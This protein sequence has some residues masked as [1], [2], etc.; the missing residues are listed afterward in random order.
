MEEIVLQT[1]RKAA[2]DH[3]RAYFEFLFKN[4]QTGDPFPVDFDTAWPLAYSSK[5]N[6]KRALVENTAFYEGEDYHILKAEDMVKRPQGGGPQT[7]KII[8]SIG[9]FEY[10][11]ARKVR[12]VFDVYRECRIVV[13]K[14]AVAKAAL[15]YHLRRYLANHEQVPFGHFS[16]LQELTTK[17]IGPLEMKGYTVPENMLPDISVGKAFCRWLREEKGL[18]PDSFPTYEHVFE[19]GRTVFPKAY[20]NHLLSDF[21]E[22]FNGEWMK[23]RAE[24][25]FGDRDE[26]SLVYLQKI[27]EGPKAS[28]QIPGPPSVP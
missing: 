20:P 24:K 25:Y 2:M 8:L 1:G 17:L 18:D 19:D 9:C 15:P 21:V 5:A 23:N 11:I 27:I 26:A 6:A 22:H 10:F 4:E 28:T 12:Q 16:I 7:E 14:A 3:V 13:T